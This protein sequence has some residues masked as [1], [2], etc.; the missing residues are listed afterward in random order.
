MLSDRTTAIRSRDYCGLSTRT[1]ARTNLRQALSNL[2][3]TINDQNADPPFL[4]VSRETV[5]FNPAADYWL[6]VAQFT[7]FWMNIQ[8]RSPPT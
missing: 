6:D 2:R 4:L 7:I 1:N 3:R 8:P 5:Q